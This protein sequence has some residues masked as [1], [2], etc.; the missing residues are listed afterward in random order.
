MGNSE[1]SKRTD[2]S[3]IHA[4]QLEMMKTLAAVFEKNGLRYALYCG[5][6]LGAIRHRGF[7]PWDDDVDLVMPLEDYRRFLRLAAK[8][9]PRGYVVLTPENSDTHIIPWAKVFLDGTTMMSKSQAAYDTH[10][11]V[12]IDIYP[13]IGECPVR[14]LRKMQTIAIRFVKLLLSLDYFLCLSRISWKGRLFR[15]LPLSLRRRIAN[16]LLHLCMRP[17]EKSRRIGSVD[18]ALFCG[19]YDRS[20]WEHMI[21]VPFEDAE[22]V[23]P[24]EYDRILTRMYGDYMTPP[25]KAWRYGHDYGAGD[26][27]YDTHKDYREYR[28]E[29][30]GV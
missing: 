27:I 26:M 1:D 24:A 6:L 28:K 2:L 13:M 12:Y 11:G 3:D 19:K 15:V 23:V 17:M 5:T 9:L 4:V 16:C 7:I 8:E 14:V 20:W 18:A 22:F 10:W 21:K 25:P 29:L 30:L